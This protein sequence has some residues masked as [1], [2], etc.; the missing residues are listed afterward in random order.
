MFLGRPVSNAAN[1]FGRSALVHEIMEDPYTMGKFSKC[2]NF[3]LTVPVFFL[4]STVISKLPY[5]TL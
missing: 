2:V 1:K 4:Q 5:N 3:I